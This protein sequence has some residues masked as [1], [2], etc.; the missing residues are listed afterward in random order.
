MTT[1]TINGVEYTTKPLTLKDASIDD[2]LINGKLDQQSILENTVIRTDALPIDWS[3]IPIGH[4]M[5]LLP[6][7][8]AAAGFDTVVTEGNA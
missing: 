8:L 6:M 1:T 3:I 7:A 5:R 4:A 2:L